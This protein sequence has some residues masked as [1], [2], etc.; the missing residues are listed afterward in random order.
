MNHPL[1]A[2]F[3]HHVANQIRNDEVDRHHRHDD[4][5]GENYPP[6]RIEVVDE[7]IEAHLRHGL[8]VAAAAWNGWGH[9]RRGILLHGATLDDCYWLRLKSMGTKA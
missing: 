7:V 3:N 9:G 2:R 1:H 5:R 8:G 4:E 6:H